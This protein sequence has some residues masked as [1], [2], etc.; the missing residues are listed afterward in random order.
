[1]EFILS[2]DHSHKS[3][4]CDLWILHL[5]LRSDNVSLCHS[6]FPF[7]LSHNVNTYQS[8]NYLSICL[9]KLNFSR[10]LASGTHTCSQFQVQVRLAVFTCFDSA[11]CLSSHRHHLS[12]FVWNSDT[13]G[14]YVAKHQI[15]QRLEGF[16]FLL[17][18]WSLQEGFIPQNEA[19]RH[20][21]WLWLCHWFVIFRSVWVKQLHNDT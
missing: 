13:W 5:Y 20:R 16:S 1:M 7:F 2:F 10:N 21:F 19:Q 8:L 18:L 15:A 3:M 11:Y 14:G 17:K 4:I 12:C 6:S 9:E